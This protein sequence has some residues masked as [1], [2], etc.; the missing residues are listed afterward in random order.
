MQDWPAGL[1]T[2]FTG[3]AAVGKGSLAA[4][5]AAVRAETAVICA[6]MFSWQAGFLHCQDGAAAVPAAEL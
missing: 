4:V 6:N 3:S 2:A 5:A 1:L